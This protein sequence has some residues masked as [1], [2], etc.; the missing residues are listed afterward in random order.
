MDTDEKGAADRFGLPTNISE[1]V[2]VAKCFKIWFC[3]LHFLPAFC[4]LKAARA[5]L[6]G[7]YDF[8]KT[9]PSTLSSRETLRR[10]EAGKIRKTL[11]AAKPKDQIQTADGRGMPQQNDRPNSSPIVRGADGRSPAAEF[12]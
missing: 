10:P 5:Y 3:G 7:P 4:C 6:P 1:A 12:R 8:A 9:A 2:T 11:E